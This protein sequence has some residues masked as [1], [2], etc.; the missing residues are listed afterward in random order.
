MY[1]IQRVYVVFCKDSKK[2]NGLSHCILF[3]LKVR[4]KN[5]KLHVKREFVKNINIVYLIK[6]KCIL[7]Y[8]EI[9]ETKETEN[10]LY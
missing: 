2:G 9:T 3:S 5:R 4:V 1:F 6:K 10:M 8:K 7:K